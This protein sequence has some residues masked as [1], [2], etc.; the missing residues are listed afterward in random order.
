[1][2]LEQD[3]FNYKFSNIMIY[4]DL[5]KLGGAEYTAPACELINLETSA[6]VCQSGDPRFG[7]DDWNE[8]EDSGINF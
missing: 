6:S 7:I 3:Y 1:M 5:Q 4:T 2:R 8:D